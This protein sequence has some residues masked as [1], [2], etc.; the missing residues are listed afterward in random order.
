MVARRLGLGQ[1]RRFLF[2]IEHEYAGVDLAEPDKL[3]CFVDRRI[4]PGYIGW[5]MSGVGI[6]Q[7]GLARSATAVQMTANDAMAAFV[8]KLA[9]IIDVRGVRP[10]AVR[11]GMIPCGGIVRPVAAPRALLVG[12]AAG[13]VSPLTA[14]GIHTALKHGHA[15]GQAIAE[16]LSGRRAD[17]ATW[18]VDSYPQFRAKRMLRWLFDRFQSD[19]IFNLCLGTK[20]MRT[21]AGIV[22]FHHK[23]VFD[24]ARERRGAEPD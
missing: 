4:A 11:A 15:A 7:V 16:H 19:A 23:G 2:G 17:P 9:P 5:A 8:E 14:G 22:Y 3:H 1:N 21:A 6:L 24:G 13:M 10:I 18:F 20:L 12:D